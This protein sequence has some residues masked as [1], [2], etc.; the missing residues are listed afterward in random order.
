MSAG[1]A[2]GAISALVRRVATDLRAGTRPTWFSTEMLYGAIQARLEEGPDYDPD[3]DARVQWLRQVRA[4]LRACVPI[5][6]GGDAEWLAFSLAGV[7]G[8]SL[9][10]GKALAA[11]EGVPR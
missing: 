6:R 1:T 2:S 3:L 10:S 4:D 7:D 11:G 5:R 9:F 8:Q